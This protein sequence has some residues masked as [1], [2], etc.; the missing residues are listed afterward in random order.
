MVAVFAVLATG[1]GS[2]ARRHPSP[3]VPAH[4]VLVP[5]EESRPP[6]PARTALVL[7]GGGANGAFAAGILK[8][9]TTT[10][11]RP[12]FDVVTGVSTGALI[13][14]FAFLGPDCDDRLGEFYIAT[15]ERDVFHRRSL[16]TALAWGDSLADPAPLRKRI[17]DEVTP[18]FLRR[19]AEEHRKGRRLYVATTDLDSKTGV[20]WDLG[21]IASGAAPGR[22]VLFCNILLASCSVPA[23]FPP[24]P[25]DVEIDGRIHTELHVDG[26]VR[27]NAFL[28]A[29][30]FGVGPNG[31][32][33][34][35]HGRAEVY[36]VLSGKLAPTRKAVE[37]RVR[38]VTEEALLG[39]LAGRQDDDLLKLH[40]LC[41]D[42]G[43]GLHVAA[44]PEEWQLDDNPLAFDAAKMHELY[45]KGREMGRS[46]HW[47][48]SGLEFSP[49]EEQVPRGGPKL[50]AVDRPPPVEDEPFAR[51]FRRLRRK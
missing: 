51:F 15:G 33:G 40:V 9:W 2:I 38:A 7:S 46:G 39:L 8:G 31:A 34:P 35:T 28:P 1:C 50:K 21:A 5:V 17:D 10:G 19:V 36:V 44:V 4:T 12:Q 20:I 25:I 49:G 6:V 24:V 3:D 41:R 11:R 14:I 26:A 47:T 43:A 22:R 13:A 27:A 32:A 23:V 29:S 48:S 18:D 37:R 30:V 16:L 42:V 45:A